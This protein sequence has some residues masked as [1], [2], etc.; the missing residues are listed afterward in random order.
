MPCRIFQG[1]AKFMPAADSKASHSPTPG[2]IL[3]FAALPAGAAACSD[4]GDPIGEGQA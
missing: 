4:R 2:G 1:S 3:H